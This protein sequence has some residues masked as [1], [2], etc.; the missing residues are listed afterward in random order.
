MKE[1]KDGNTE[2]VNIDQLEKSLKD[3][4]PDQ[5]KN[6][7]I[8][9]EPVWAINNKFLNPDM[10]PIPATPDQAKEVHAFVRAWLV[11]KYG[12]EIGNKVAIQYGGSMN[13]SNAVELLAIE[14]I[15]GGLI[16]SASLDAAAFEPIIKAAQDK[17]K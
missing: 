4:Q 5:M 6:V 10:D 15:N 9:Y 8:A 3:V 16:G 14:N 12:A 11:K 13:K 2:S 7:V 1:R 17:S